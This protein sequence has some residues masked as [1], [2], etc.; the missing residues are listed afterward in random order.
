MLC[1]CQAGHE[2]IARLLVHYGAQV[3]VTSFSG[4][5]PLQYAALC[6][7]QGLVSF[8]L[9]SG[10]CIDTCDENNR[11]ALH[12]ASSEG[13]LEIC[14]TLVN[15]LIMPN[16]NMPTDPVE[17]RIAHQKKLTFIDATDVDNRTALLDAAERGHLDVVKYLLENSA[18]LSIADF[19]GRNPLHVSCGEGHTQVV[20]YLLV[21]GAS[22]GTPDYNQ[23]FPLHWASKHGKTDI[24]EPL[25]EKGAVVG[26]V[27]AMQDTPLHL[28]CDGGHIQVILCDV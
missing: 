6:G 28:A 4:N 13:H 3:N 14:Q 7:N 25:I 11:T 1:A 20:E 10:A 22:V 9:Q 18:D 8:L 27:D 23:R 17:T 2:N 16:S 5:T 15:H 12:L 21:K 26:V 24:V 19:S